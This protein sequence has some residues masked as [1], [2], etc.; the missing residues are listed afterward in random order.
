M[1]GSNFFN[2]EGKV[3]F[4]WTAMRSLR[5]IAP[6]AFIFCTACLAL[7]LLGTARAV[8]SG[9]Q[10]EATSPLSEVKATVSRAVAI[11]H[12]QQM[13][14]EQRRREL[15]QLAENRLDL[16]K[17]ARGSLGDHWDELAPAQRD[18]FVSLFTAFIEDAYL[19][20]IQDYVKLNIDVTSETITAPGY[21]RVAATVL[22]P[23][24][25]P[26]PIVFMLERRGDDWIVYDVSVEDVSMVKNYRAQFDHV[27]KSQGM[28]QLLS[29]LRQKKDRLA[30]LVGER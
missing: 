18:V 12:D 30:A 26:L 5:R 1:D 24:E 25:D 4:S 6:P 10:A 8:W 9:T 28:P 23:H 21:A 11:L 2:A 22:Q 17:M 7:V 16:A 3:S 27:I 14:V 13:S 15:Q 19:V 29:E 20:Q